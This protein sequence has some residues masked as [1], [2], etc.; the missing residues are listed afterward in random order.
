M[1]T[2]YD[3][4]SLSVGE[5][6]TGESIL[7]SG[8]IT[9]EYNSTARSIVA[10]AKDHHLDCASRTYVS[11]NALNLPV[12]DRPIAHPGVEHCSDCGAKLFEW[13][14]GEH[15]S[16][17]GVHDCS[18]VTQQSGHGLD[19][20][21]CLTLNAGLLDSRCNYLGER[22]INPQD[23]ISKGLY[24]S[25]VRVEGETLI[26][27]S[28]QTSSRVVVEAKVQ[29]GVHHPGHRNG[30]SRPDTQQQGVAGISQTTSRSFLQTGHRNLEGLI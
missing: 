23:D 8:W 6:V 24:E 11:V 10:V 13:V 28:S 16:G 15:R 29:D 17:S 14:R 26:G 9:R 4:L 12:L 30:R 21:V 3:V 27:G 22:C 2:R 1:G 18:Q 25:T 5:E 7:T 19:T 20:Q